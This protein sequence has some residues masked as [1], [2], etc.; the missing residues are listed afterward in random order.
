MRLRDAALSVADPDGPLPITHV[1]GVPVAGADTRGLRMVRLARG[2]MLQLRRAG[3]VGTAAVRP[4]EETSRRG[5]RSIALR[6][7][8]AG[9][10]TWFEI[11]PSHSGITRGGC[12]RSVT[13]DPYGYLAVPGGRWAQISLNH[14]AERLQLE[15]AQALAGTLAG[16]VWDDVVGA[17]SG[18]GAIWLREAWAEDGV[19]VL[20]LDGSIGR[21]RAVVAP[22]RR[23]TSVRSIDA[24]GVLMRVDGAYQD[25]LTD[26]LAGALGDIDVLGRFRDALVQAVH[27]HL[28]TL[29]EDVRGFEVD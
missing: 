3:V 4:H 23:V 14:G 29:P 19:V 15:L 7:A 12:L 26:R 1:D 16:A 27:A 24:S 11:I 25:Y 18:R 22:G 8:P 13:G 17:R 28:P 6:V 10:P 5:T 20:I 2:L 21:T 9:T